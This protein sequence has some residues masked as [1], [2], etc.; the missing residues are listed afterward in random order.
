MNLKRA[1]KGAMN[2]APTEALNLKIAPIFRAVE[3]PDSPTGA[4]S[5]GSIELL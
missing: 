3:S 2:R 4:P 5:M 1:W